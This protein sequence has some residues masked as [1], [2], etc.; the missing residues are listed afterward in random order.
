MDIEKPI[1]QSGFLQDGY[2]DHL[3]TAQMQKRK[4]IIQTKTL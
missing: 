3:A 2:I 1:K 4:K